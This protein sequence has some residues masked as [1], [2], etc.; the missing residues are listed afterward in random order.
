MID[1][2]PYKNAWEVDSFGI[3]A[4]VTAEFFYFGQSTEVG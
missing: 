3:F 2:S 4:E 1:H